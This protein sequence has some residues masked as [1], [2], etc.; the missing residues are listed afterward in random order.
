MKKAATLGFWSVVLLTLTSVGGCQRSDTVN[1]NFLQLDQGTFEVTGPYVHEN[2][3]VFLLHSNEQD[4]REFITLDQ[5]L[6]DGVVKVSE[7]NQAQV[8]QLEINNESDQY[9][10]LQ[11]GDR[12]VGG[13][14]D[15]IIITSLVI[16]PKSGNMPLPSF[17][18]EA[19]RWQ[20]QKAFR[21]GG[22]TALAPKGVRQASKVVNL[23][24]QVWDSV[25]DYKNSANS[26]AN[27]NAPNTNTSLNE[28][29]EAPQ[30][31]KMSDEY[32]KALENILDEHPRAVGVVVAINGGIEEINIYPNHKVLSSQYPRL[33]RSYA[34]QA[35]MEEKK[36]D[37]T[38]EMTVADVRNFMTERKEQAEEQKRQVNSDNYLSVC[39]SADK[40]ECQT[41]YS[42]KV[43]HR[44]WLGNNEAMAKQAAPAPQ[45]EAR[46]QQS[47]APNAAPEDNVQREAPRKQAPA[48]KQ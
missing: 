20:G 7:Q 4:D 2:M 16:P 44:Q 37:E 46:G 27:V 48:P 47:A 18:V 31:Q 42:G 17:C 3:T 22:N 36:G 28:T 45:N 35:A 9:L 13:Q 41:L 30:V 43:V 12:V 19:G 6:K 14:Q 21:A 29:L 38:A 39:P 23:Q 10:F 5:G 24:Q 32:A 26:S 34:L 1:D 15:R 33:L 8:N 25:R 11:E 40:T